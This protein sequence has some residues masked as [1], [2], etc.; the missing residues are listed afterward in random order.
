MTGMRRLLAACLIPAMS[1]AGDMELDEAPLVNMGV[2][3]SI[4]EAPYVKV[5]TANP[6][7]MAIQ[8]VAPSVVAPLPAVVSRQS[9][10]LMLSAIDIPV[11]ADALSIL[12][13]RLVPVVNQWMSSQGAVAIAIPQDGLVVQE[14]GAIQLPRQPFV[15]SQVL[16]AQEEFKQSLASGEIQRLSSGQFVLANPAVMALPWFRQAMQDGAMIPSQQYALSPAPPALVQSL[17][18]AASSPAWQ[19]VKPLS[20]SG[21]HA[22]SYF[23]SALEAGKVSQVVVTIGPAAGVVVD[24]LAPAVQTLEI[25]GQALQGGFLSSLLGA[26]GGGVKVYVIPPISWDGRSYVV[27]SAVPLTDE[28]MSVARRAIAAAVGAGRSPGVLVIAPIGASPAVKVAVLDE[29]TV[30]KLGLPRTHGYEWLV[31]RG[32]S[33]SNAVSWVKAMTD[34]PANGIEA[35]FRDVGPLFVCSEAVPT[36]DE[37]EFA[38]QASAIDSAVAKGRNCILLAYHGGA[39]P[40]SVARVADRIRSAGAKVLLAVSMGEGDDD[41]GGFGVSEF[42]SVL[43]ALDGRI[44]YFLPCWRGCSPLHL[45]GSQSVFVQWVLMLALRK[46]PD[47]VVF[48]A[49][50]IYRGRAV[51]FVPK[52][53]SA[54]FVL[55]PMSDRMDMFKYGPSSASRFGADGAKVIRGP[56]CYPGIYA[57]QDQERKDAL[58]KEFMGHGFSFFEFSGDGEEK[59]DRMTK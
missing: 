34:V 29:R 10:V 55:S 30:S 18:W 36:D 19:E 31:P 3:P 26:T 39:S 15:A 38:R 37:Q 47:M 13:G 57:Q 35:R 23:V 11:L 8:V 22:E 45:S 12:A 58:A 51:S 50:D 7:P 32:M 54:V 59:N 14:I 5:A 40:A 28:Q 25:A 17:P 2:M 1:I 42:S 52:G 56:V 24:L 27:M 9:P 41:R 48:G 53:A 20:P 44:D 4:G 6:A 49:V 43:D 33:E 16:Q 21:S 46:S